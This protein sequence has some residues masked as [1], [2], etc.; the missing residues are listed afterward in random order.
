MKTSKPLHWKSNLFLLA[1]SLFVAAG[2]RESLADAGSIPQNPSQGTPDPSAKGLSP[3]AG[4]GAVS[5]AQDVPL[6]LGANRFNS[7]ADKPL[8]ITYRL[9]KRGKISLEIYN[10]NGELVRNLADKEL[11]PGIYAIFWDGKDDNGRW[12]R[13]GQY[14]IVLTGKNLFESQKVNL[15]SQ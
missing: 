14:L 12:L 11:L 13:P 5:I 1:V 8:R 7:R 6:V 10:P 15:V 4:E 3:A 9:F 2:W